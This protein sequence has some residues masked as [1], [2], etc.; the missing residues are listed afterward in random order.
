MNRD[1]IN[2]S[3]EILEYDLL[4][5]EEQELLTEISIGKVTSTVFLGRLKLLTRKI[6][7]INLKKTL[8]NLGYMIYTVSLQQKS[9]DKLDKKLDNLT[10]QLKK[11]EIETNRLIQKQKNT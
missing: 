10:T 7:D 6:K 8:M 5:S 4:D 3:K 2:K 1:L 11:Q 9:L